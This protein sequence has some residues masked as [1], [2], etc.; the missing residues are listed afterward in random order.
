M[1]VESSKKST[2]T[3]CFDTVVLLVTCNIISEPYTLDK[4]IAFFGL[5]I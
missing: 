5:E 2:W 1:A 3:D 4:F